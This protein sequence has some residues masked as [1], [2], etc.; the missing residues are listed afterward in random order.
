M[1]RYCID[2]GTMIAQ[3]GV[4]SYLFNG[5]TKLEDTVCSQRYRTDEMEIVWPFSVCYKLSV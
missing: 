2:N 5:A 3:A 4:L 1:N